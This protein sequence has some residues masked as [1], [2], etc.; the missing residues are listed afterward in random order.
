MVNNLKHYFLIFISIIFISCGSSSS[1]SSNSDDS[2]NTD[3]VSNDITT[4]DSSNDTIETIWYKPSSNITWQWQLK[5]KLNLEYKVDL[6]DV[7]LFD[8]DIETIQSIKT[9]GAK[10]ICYFSAGSYEDWRSDKDDFPLE[11]LGDDLDG[12]EG[13][14]WLDISNLDTLKPIML[15]RLDL[16]KQKACD[17]VESDNVD[18]YTNSTGFSLTK[19]DQITYNKFLAQEAHQRGLSIALKNAV[20]IIDELEPYF[21]F[22]LNEQCNQYN[23]CEEY[24]AFINSNKAVLN[25]EYNSKYLDDD[26]M[27][28]LCNYTNNLNISTLILPLD[29][30]D[31]FRHDCKNYVYDKLQVGYGGSSSFKFYDN[32]WLNSTDLMH[33]N[34]D[35]VKDEILDFNQSQFNILSTHLQKSKYITYWFTKGWEESWFNLNKIKES[36]ENG[37][38]PVFV[39]WYFGDEMINGITSSDISGYLDDVKK[40]NTFL[41]TIKGEHF[42]IL[43]PEFNKKEI[44]NNQENQNMFIQA[45]KDSS[46]ILKKQNR[47]LSLCMMDTGSRDINSINSCGYDNCSYGDKNEWDKVEPIYNALLNELDFISFQQMVGQFSRD[48]SNPGTW[49]D[50]NPKAYTSSELG[51]DNLA[52]RIDNFAI[53]LKEKYN[54]PVFLPY[55]TIATATWD[56][57]NDDDIIDSN[58]LNSSGWIT[59]AS[60]TYRDLNSTSLFGYSVMSLFDNPTH[61]NGGY[62]YFMDNEYHLG[63]ISS[64]INNSQITGNIKFKGDILQ[65]VFK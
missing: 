4:D 9:T 38:I 48:D 34:F 28:K 5:D 65:N 6:Y 21:D 11:V 52:K 35:S 23:E 36:I 15:K 24:Q 22:A 53:Y 40:L 47:K 58:E 62:Q 57:I 19:E 12:W 42:I 49:D 61:D 33:G 39:Y 1:T 7:D 3:N 46:T 41:D 18:G 55:I 59:K 54:K 13:E 2:S 14:K 51:I 63:I 29:L 43:E 64:D 56:D 30:N 60:N 50:P 32:I 25:A 37:K 31:T 20:D 17:G 8:T 27:T 26:N 16:A 44:L 10:V 45:I